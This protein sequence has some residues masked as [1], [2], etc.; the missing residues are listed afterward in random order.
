MASG[1]PSDEPSMHLMDGSKNDQFW[2]AAEGGRS[3]DRSEGSLCPAQKTFRTVQQTVV[4]D[5][6]QLCSFELNMH[7]TTANNLIS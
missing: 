6:Q 7:A 5:I 4:F 2:N 1:G 3:R